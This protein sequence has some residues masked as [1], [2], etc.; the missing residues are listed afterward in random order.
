MRVPRRLAAFG[1]GSRAV[2]VAPCAPSNPSAPPYAPLRVPL[3]QSFFSTFSPAAFEPLMAK[4]L[5]S[6]FSKPVFGVAAAASLVASV[7]TREQRGEGKGSY[8]NTAIVKGQHF[9]LN[10][11]GSFRSL[12]DDGRKSYAL[13]AH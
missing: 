8:S 3:L 2:R 7:L 4:H 6:G 12:Y 9:R 1:W 13:R 5:G 10:G 11:E